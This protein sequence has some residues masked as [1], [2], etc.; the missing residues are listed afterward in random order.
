MLYDN[1]QI[2]EYL[3]NLWA[4][5]VQEPAIERA[6]ARTIQW[7]KREMRSPSG[8]F[9]AAQDADSFSN[10]TE[11]EPEEGAFYVWDYDQLNTLLTPADLAEL[12]TEFT[13]TADGN[14]EG[15][16]VLQRHH[17]GRLSDNL[18]AAL[19][20]LFV[21]RYGKNPEDLPVFP[22]ARNNQE[23]K[24]TT[25]SGRIPPV[26]DTKLIVAWNS[27]M[28]SGLAR[29]SS[30]FQQPEYLTLARQ[31][32][33]FILE[34]Q[35]RDRRFHRINYDGKP[36]VLAQSEDYALFIK[37]LLD[38]HQV[39]LAGIGQG[40][41]PT[42]A[43]RYLAHAVAVQEEFDEHLWSVELGGYYTADAG[44]D[45]LVRERS[46]IDNATPAANGIAVANLVRL[47]LLTEDLDYLD[48]AE[49]TLQAF[50]QVMERSPQA[51]PSLF[52][53][54]DWFFNHT[55]IRTSSDAIAQLLPQYH[56]T[57]VYTLASALP[58]DAI[59]LVCQ[60]LS[61]QEPA[62]T[63]EQLHA[64]IQQSQVRNENTLR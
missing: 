6:I 5:G 39:S 61:C 3:S 60:G 41:S 17:S 56:P 29:A 21:V 42:N 54:F 49:Q 16:N 50:G 9:Y 32:A 64:Q 43:Q 2:V 33:Q 8:Y 46:Y 35:W 48:K 12:T 27:L 22:P 45:L 19:S 11:A 31:A 38:L 57:A 23:A 4:M 40:S 44:S 30:V 58:A 24:E 18:D 26:T 20:Q 25:W 15:Y 7:L 63:P 62:R 47:A 51:C 28:I 37:A 14:F 52:S 34:Q 13:V 55:L 10:A 36:E 53:G 1:G 59:A